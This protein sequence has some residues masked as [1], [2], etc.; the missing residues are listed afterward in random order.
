MLQFMTLHLA[1]T[2]E[3]PEGDPECGYEIVVPIDANGHLDPEEWRKNRSLCRVRKFWRG[4][5]D[6]HGLFVHHP[7]GHDG[8]TWKVICGI[9]NKPGQYESESGVRFDGH[10]F[11]NGEYVSFRDED[12]GTQTYKIAHIIPYQYR[13]H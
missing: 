5:N 8:A 13:Y 4:E 9:T 3:R 12:G 6:Q 2:H 10:L 7:G 11:S 1:R